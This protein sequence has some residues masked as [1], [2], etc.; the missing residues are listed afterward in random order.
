MHGVSGYPSIRLLR[1]GYS[2]EY[3]GGRN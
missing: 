1:D 2:R 3:R